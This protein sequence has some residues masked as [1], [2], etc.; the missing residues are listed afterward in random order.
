ML[1]T[2]GNLDYSTAF[3]LTPII[4]Q[5]IISIIGICLLLA[6]MGKSAQLGLHI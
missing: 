1:W 5:D 2:F 3:S 6:A 4:N